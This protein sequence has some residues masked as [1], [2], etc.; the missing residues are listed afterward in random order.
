VVC[1]V[2]LFLFFLLKG[3]NVI[4]FENYLTSFYLSS[5]VEALVVEG[6]GGIQSK[7]CWQFFPFFF[8]DKLIMLETYINVP[9]E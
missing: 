1:E 2:Y 6:M 9:H 4:T 3:K 7:E 8:K 5:K